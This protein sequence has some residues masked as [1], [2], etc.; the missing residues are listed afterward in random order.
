MYVILQKSKKD[1]KNKV[2]QFL[3]KNA[4]PSDKRIHALAEELD[5]DPSELEAVIYS[6]LSEIIH[7]PKI[8]ESDVDP[9]ELKIGIKIELEHTS[10]P[11]L[12]KYIAL[13]HLEELPDYYTK[14]QEM[15][16]KK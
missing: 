14:L 6:I 5:I 7:K 10:V 3:A 1:V 4:N 16:S 8:K 15:E 12:A 13:A 9:K 2:V 11:A